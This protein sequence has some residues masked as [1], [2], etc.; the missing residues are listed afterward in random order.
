VDEIPGT[1]RSARRRYTSSRPAPEPASGPRR[2]GS[3]CCSGRAGHT[4]SRHAADLSQAPPPGARWSRDVPHRG[5]SGRSVSEGGRHLSASAGPPIRSGI[6]KRHA[7]AGSSLRRRAGMTPSPCASRREARECPGR[8][9]RP[10]PAAS[11]P[12]SVPR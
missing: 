9:P 5:R 4:A 12:R 3:C 6:E 1:R 11:A 7:V 2:S 10:S 8:M